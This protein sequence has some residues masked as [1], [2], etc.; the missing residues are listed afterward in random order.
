MI[1]VAE[2]SGFDVCVVSFYYFALDS[3]SLECDDPCYESADESSAIYVILV[4]ISLFH[5]GSSSSSS[6]SLGE[7]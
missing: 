1:K 4:L 3:L 5:R 6:F 7:V 2:A